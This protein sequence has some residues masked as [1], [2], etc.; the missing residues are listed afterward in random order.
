MVPQGALSWHVD[1]RIL[2]EKLL[3]HLR[4]HVLI[5]TVHVERRAYP[6]W[7]PPRRPKKSGRRGSGFNF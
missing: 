7:E 3:G 6:A 5:L 1:R 4:F 2:N